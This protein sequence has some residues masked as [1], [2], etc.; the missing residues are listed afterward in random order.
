MH[1][2]CLMLFESLRWTG[3][4]K[5]VVQV[6]SLCYSNIP[7]VSHHIYPQ[8]NLQAT[9]SPA[10]LPFGCSAHPSLAPSLSSAS[11]LPRVFRWLNP[12][13]LPV[14][15]IF[16]WLNPLLHLSICSN[17]TSSR[18]S[19][20]TTLS[21]IVSTHHLSLWTNFFFSELFVCFISDPFPISLYSL[22]TAKVDSYKLHI[23]ASWLP[24][25]FV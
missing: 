7:M 9:S 20:L 17:V 14:P 8:S 19:F 16:R 22:C 24:V 23:S 6:P 25:K 1:F 10:G 5:S 12:F 13:P 11:F 4:F 21:K 2:Q 15:K 3:P 18:R